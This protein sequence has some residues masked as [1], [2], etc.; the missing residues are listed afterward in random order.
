MKNWLVYYSYKTIPSK[1]HM[2]IVS[3]KERE[4]AKSKVSA[5]NPK[6]IK[7]GKAFETSMRCSW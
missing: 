2:I 4:T 3:S 6:E 1:E 7:V 5:L